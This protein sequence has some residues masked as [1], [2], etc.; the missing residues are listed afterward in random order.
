MYGDFSGIHQQRYRL[1]CIY[2][3]RN[4]RILSGFVVNIRLHVSTDMA[5]VRNIEIIPNQFN[6]VWVRVGLSYAPKLVTEL[7]TYQLQRRCWRRRVGSDIWRHQLVSSSQ[8]LRSR[9]VAKHFAFSASVQ[10]WHRQ[11]WL[12]SKGKISL[13][14]FCV[15]QFTR[16]GLDFVTYCTVKAAGVGG[17]I[18]RITFLS[19]VLNIVFSLS[20][21]VF[22]FDSNSDWSD[23]VTG[24]RLSDPPF[25]D[26]MI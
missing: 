8:K 26:I 9:S 1:G 4:T 20:Y 14:Q 25:A 3:D 13:Y 6:V 5:M 15:S 2:E 17:G 22:V 16:Q 12:L 21:T 19:F 18:I 11:W 10:S 7:F 23:I 24:I